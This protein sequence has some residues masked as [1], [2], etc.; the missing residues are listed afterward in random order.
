MTLRRFLVETWQRKRLA[1]KR[2]DL[3]IVEEIPVLE[4]DDLGIRS[5]LLDIEDVYDNQLTVNAAEV[6]IREAVVS[7]KSRRVE[8]TKT[9]SRQN[10]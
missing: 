3:R 5:I 1:L 2:E 4:L 6:A 9:A 8:N 10:T 7:A